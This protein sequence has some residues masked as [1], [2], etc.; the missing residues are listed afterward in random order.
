MLPILKGEAEVGHG[1]RD[2]GG[3][4]EGRPAEHGRSAVLELAHLHLLLLVL[5]LGPA[6]ERVVE[7]GRLPRLLVL[8]LGRLNTE[9]RPRQTKTIIQ[10]EG[11][12]SRG[13]RNTGICFYSRW[14]TTVRFA[15]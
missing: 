3:G 7:R 11:A 2:E 4:D 10:G 14:L 5:R 1:S 9:E 6:L 12:W 8:P 15:D 13:K